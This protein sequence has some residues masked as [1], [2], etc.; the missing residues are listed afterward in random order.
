[1]LKNSP[2]H[3]VLDA[4]AIEELC[5]RSVTKFGPGSDATLRAHLLP[6]EGAEARLPSPLLKR[7]LRAW[8]KAYNEPDKQDALWGNTSWEKD[9]RAG[10]AL[11]SQYGELIL[12]D[13]AQAAPLE[14]DDAPFGVVVWLGAVVED[15]LAPLTNLKGL[16]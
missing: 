15:F 14:G 13:W 8:W 11:V 1:M 10:L 7:H 5:R 12:P 6:L 2:A 3:F 16:L 9:Y 4:S